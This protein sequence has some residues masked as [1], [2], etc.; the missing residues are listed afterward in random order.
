[1]AVMKGYGF[2]GERMAVEA[3]FTGQIIKKEEENK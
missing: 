3:T 2:V 1:M